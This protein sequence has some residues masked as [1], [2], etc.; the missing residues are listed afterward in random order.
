MLTDSMLTDSMLTDSMLTDSMPT[1]VDAELV[2]RYDRQ[3]PRYTSY[4]TAMEFSQLNTTLYGE[5]LSRAA[6]KVDEPLSLYLHLPFCA[7]RCLFCG[8]NAVVT[9]RREIAEHYLQVL[10]S[11]IREVARRLGGRRRL[12]QHHWGGGTPTYLTPAEMQR[13]YAVVSEHFD[14]EPDAEVAIEIDPR[15]TTPEH[16]EM[17]WALG[18]NRLSLGVQDF[19]PEVQEEIHR[20]Q[21]FELTRDLVEF[22]RSLGFQSTNI[23]LIYGLPRQSPSTFRR[24]LRQ[25]LEI[26]PERIAVY[27]YA[28][29]PWLKVQ[30]R[31]I[32]EEHLP[33]ADVKLELIASA[34]STLRGAGYLAIGM[35]HFALPEDDLGR[36][37]T[38]GTLWRN[39][40]GYT[41]RHAP[42]TIACGMSSIGDVDGAYFQNER[43][44][45]HYQDAVEA[46]GLA[47]E[48]GIVLSP[49][50]QLRRYV[51]TALMC[52][53]HLDVDDVERRFAVDFATTFAAE[54]EALRPLEDD[55]LVALGKERITVM[56]KGHLFVRNICMAFDGYLAR[57]SSDKKSFSRTV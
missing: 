32:L 13:L 47:V 48:R 57:Y 15:V 27:S 53:F 30:Q 10:K 19:T 3:G 14:V 20:V 51:I 2:R 29:V 9:R 7:E 6:T 39:F 31:R 38:E 22:G 56:E 37:I 23:D 12:R 8:C 25:V 26:R 1:E 35:D 54:L 16:L 41:V 21:S 18:F 24:T 33:S 28:H 44:L 17:A 50:D 34:V 11:E 49:D 45:K 36:A 46:G 42:D 55:G 43:K 5:H 52:T 4:P 40:M